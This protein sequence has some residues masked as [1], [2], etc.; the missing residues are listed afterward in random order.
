M[1][2]NARETTTCA[3]YNYGLQYMSLPC[4]AEEHCCGVA[5]CG[6]AWRG[7]VW[8]GVVCAVVLHALQQDSV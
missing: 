1:R 5:E 7:V 3:A 6:M 2:H 8:C 4:A